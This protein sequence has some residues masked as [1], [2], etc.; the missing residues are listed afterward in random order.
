MNKYIKKTIYLLI[1][2]LLL[3][4]IS[5]CYAYNVTFTWE[6]DSN[7]TDLEGFFLY[8]KDSNQLYYDYNTPASSLIDANIRSYTHKNVMEGVRSWVLRARSIYGD[9]SEDSNEVSYAIPLIT[10]IKFDV[11]G[12][13]SGDIVDVLFLSG[14]SLPGMIVI[15]YDYDS[16]IWQFRRPGIVVKDFFIPG[17]AV[18]AIVRVK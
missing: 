5:V 15:G 17:V 9:Y 6:Y 2:I 11:N 7:I 10:P 16:N 14:G 13:M 18:K 8:E 4:I 3:A 12:L 1:I